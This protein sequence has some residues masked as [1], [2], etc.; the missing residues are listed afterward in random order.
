[1]FK[2]GETGFYKVSDYS[3]KQKYGKVFEIKH[4]R[5][6]D[7]EYIVAT[8]QFEDNS[9]AFLRRNYEYKIK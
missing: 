1:M 3:T 2:T 6:I 7:G 8:I 5:D 4:Y 9:K